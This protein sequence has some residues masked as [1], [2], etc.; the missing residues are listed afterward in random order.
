[1]GH[2]HPYVVDAPDAPGTHAHTHHPVSAE[3]PLQLAEELLATMPPELGNV[4]FTCTGS[5]ANDLAV[6]VSRR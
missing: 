6:R 5:E 3:L 1:V 2:C 4:V